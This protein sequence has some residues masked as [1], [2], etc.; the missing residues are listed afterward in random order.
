MGRRGSNKYTLCN[1]CSKQETTEKQVSKFL[2]HFFPGIQYSKSSYMGG[3]FCPQV[4]A[5]CTGAYPDKYIALQDR[6]VFIE[7][8]EDSHAQYDPS[9]ELARYDKLQYGRD[10][11][12]PSLCIRFNPGGKT[13]ERRMRCKVLVQAVRDYINAALRDNVTPVMTVRHLLYDSSGE[14][15]IYAVQNL[16]EGTLVLQQEPITVTDNDILEY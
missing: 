4:G 8:D 3:K 6:V 2:E 7:V 12:K 11:I 16:A 10:C 9:C 15:H 14:Q 13:E 1:S 5:G